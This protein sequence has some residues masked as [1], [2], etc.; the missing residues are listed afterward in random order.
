METRSYPS[1]KEE[2]VI[3]EAKEVDKMILVD[4]LIITLVQTTVVMVEVSMVEINQGTVVVMVSHLAVEAKIIAT[5]VETKEIEVE[6]EK[7][8]TPS[9]MSEGLE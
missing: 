8:L 9:Q 4:R 6:A 1:Q 3:L 5:L 2:E 7:D